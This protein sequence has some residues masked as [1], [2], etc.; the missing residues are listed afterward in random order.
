MATNPNLSYIGLGPMLLESEQ[1]IANQR[2]VIDL[3]VG[4]VSVACKVLLERSGLPQDAIRNFEPHHVIT[5]AG[6]R[7]TGKTSVLMSAIREISTTVRE[8]LVLDIIHPDQIGNKLLPMPSLI[9]SFI[10]KSLEAQVPKLAQRLEHDETLRLRHLGWTLN[11]DETFHVV[12]RDSL[13]TAEWNEKIFNLFARAIDPASLFHKWIDTVLPL[14]ARE[15][16]VVPIDDADIAI[17][18]AEEIVDTLRTY[19]ASPRVIT[20]LAIDIPS[21][22]RRIRNKRLAALPPVPEFKGDG[23][24]PSFLF[25]LTPSA[26]QS[27]EAKAEHEYV[28][29]LLTKVLPQAARCYLAGLSDWERLNRPFRMPGQKAAV[30][31]V[32]IL[33][34]A[35]GGANQLQFGVTMAEVVR[36]H[37]EIFSDNIRRYA[38]QYLMLQDACTR[39]KM[40]TRTE[41]LAIPLADT[42]HALGQSLG[43]AGQVNERLQLRPV[44]TKGELLRSRFH[45]DIVRSFL[46]SSEFGPLLDYTHR[47]FGIDLEHFETMHEFVQ[48]VLL[49]GSVNETSDSKIR[50]NI[51]GRILDSDATSGLVDLCIDWALGNGVTME[52]VLDKLNLSLSDL[53]FRP[54]PI[55]RSLAIHFTSRTISMIDPL[56]KVV[57]GTSQ[58]Y[59]GP[60]VII[61]ADSSHLV[62]SFVNN[63]NALGRYIHRVIN[64]VRVRRVESDALSYIKDQN[65]KRHG[66]GRD[67]RAAT[68]RLFGLLT[69]Q[70]CFHIESLLCETLYGGSLARETNESPFRFRGNADFAWIVVEFRGLL[71]SIRQ[72]LESDQIDDAK[73]ALALAYLGDL[74]LRVALGAM[75]SPTA[76]E[77]REEVLLHIGKFLDRLTEGGLLFG[78]RRGSL[79]VGRIRQSPGQRPSEQFPGLTWTTRLEALSRLILSL[80]EAKFVGHW[81]GRSEPPPIW[82]AIASRIVRRPRLQPKRKA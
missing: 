48:F 19:L 42:S 3:V 67:L 25:G 18:K 47:N 7:G 32:Q 76:D 17:D 1:M 4:R 30:S 44:R 56:L 58:N 77:E 34:S 68:L 75:A 64:E 21:L 46:A 5:I 10:E 9:V 60:R 80:K 22:E 40:E 31:L 54:V 23:P 82:S 35:E 14:A 41:E 24:S 79:A 53:S 13:N 38:N 2:E 66:K 50:Y 11:I 37:P 74:P 43:R 26:F 45:M 81:E 39:Y 69:L 15:L 29:S 28:E 36:E 72:I 20:V 63:S 62:P 27:S 6:G 59:I 52:D 16:V 51:G 71:T 61:P 8:A 12:S 49:R 65:E 33:E 57:E 78:R 55:P 70:T 73:R